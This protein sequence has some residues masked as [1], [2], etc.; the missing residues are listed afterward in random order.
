MM[1]PIM[2]MTAVDLA[3]DCDTSHH[4]NGEE[5][6]HHSSLEN[7][8]ENHARAS[9]ISWT[10]ETWKDLFIFVNK[11]DYYYQLL[12]IINSWLTFRFKKE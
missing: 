2:D 7:I 1:Y 10:L 3:Y 9:W 8:N 5:L 11:N 12:F 4:S 6:E